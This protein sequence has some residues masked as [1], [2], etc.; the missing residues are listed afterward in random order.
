MASYTAHT[1]DVLVKMWDPDKVS[2]LC[3]WLNQCP[4]LY[5]KVVEQ[6]YQLNPWSRGDRLTIGSTHYD[7]FEIFA[8]AAIALDRLFFYSSSAP[9]LRTI[10]K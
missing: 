1:V 9:V 8:P 10:S 5:R 6:V 2:L 3:L 7:H 4:E